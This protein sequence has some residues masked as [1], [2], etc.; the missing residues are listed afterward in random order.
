MGEMIGNIA[1]QWKQPLNA[2]G[3]VLTNLQE[4][5]AAG[6]LDDGAVRL[7]VTKGRALVRRMAWTID[8][9][10]NFFRPNK[11]AVPFSVKT[12]IEQA[13]GLVDASLKHA[14]IA[15]RVDAPE[16]LV[17]LGLPNEF[18][19]VLL[20]LVVNARD[21]IQA[22]GATGGWV[23][24]AAR[25][26]GGDGVVTVRDNGGGIPDELLERIFEPFFSTRENGTGIGLYMSR[27]I[28]ERSMK[29]KI[30]A[31]NVSPGAEFAVTCSLAE[32]AAWNPPT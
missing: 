32:D 21:A 23:E 18:A 29:G 19:Q 30:V 11:E 6:E 28:I 1:H 27:M 31:R 5:H 10:R 8:D 15:V 3:L 26:E 14:G 7:A 22:S 20:N 9:F 16:D 25:R 12:Q 4:S 24:L 2:L 17:L 13:L